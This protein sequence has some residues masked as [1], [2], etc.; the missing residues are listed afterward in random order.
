[1][2]KSQKLLVVYPATRQ[3]GRPESFACLGRTCPQTAWMSEGLPHSS[4]RG[5]NNCR[6]GVARVRPQEPEAATERIATNNPTTTARVN[7][8]LWMG[9]RQRQ[10]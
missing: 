1:M 2:G 10:P 3:W 5:E 4:A 6:V 7:E 9:R 8:T